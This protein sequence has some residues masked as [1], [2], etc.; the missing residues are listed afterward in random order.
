MDTDEFDYL[1]PETYEGCYSR[2][3]E[4]SVMLAQAE[5]D[6]AFLNC[7]LRA[8]RAEIERMKGH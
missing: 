2:L 1:R 6:V 8:A 4:P 7:A 5:R 3:G